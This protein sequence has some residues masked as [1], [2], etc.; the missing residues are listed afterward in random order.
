MSPEEIREEQAEPTSDLYSF[1]VLLAE[2]ISGK[3]TP[4]RRAAL[5]RPPT[6]SATCKEEPRPL[7]VEGR[8]GIPEDLPGIILQLLAKDPA[9]RFASGEAARR[10]LEDII[11]PDVVRL[12]TVADRHVLNAWR[13]RVKSSLSAT[14]M[15]NVKDTRPPLGLSGDSKNDE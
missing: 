15:R 12:N 3:S 8:P 11:I 13:K 9:H 10:A 5:G 1:G 14:R 6:S 7:A 4:T 2:L